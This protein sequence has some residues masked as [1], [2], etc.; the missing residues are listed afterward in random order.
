MALAPKQRFTDPEDFGAHMADASRGGRIEPL[1]RGPFQ[2]EV[3]LALLPRTALFMVDSSNVLALRPARGDLWSATVPM[4]GGFSA[5][6][7]GAGSQRDFAAGEIHL[8]HPDRDFE[9]RSRETNRALAVN[10]LSDDLQQKAAALVAARPGQPTEV[11]TG[12]SPAGAALTRFVHHFW[13]ELQRPG[14]LWDSTMA[15]AEM[16]DCLVSLLALAAHPSAAAS[17]AR[18]STVRKA[19]DFLIRHL[20]QPLTRSDLAEAVGASIRTI[21]RGFREHHGVSP[22]AW[23]KARRLEA[24]Q[25]ELRDAVPGEVTVTEVALRCGFESLG[26]FAAEYR[27]RFGETPSQTLRR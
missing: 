17:T 27:A 10:I 13:A 5:T 12:A 15:L 21:S 3:S 18:L 25:S 7:G 4:Q 2:V 6:V 11:V 8:L 23:L 9:Y 22:M 26:R 1:K 16:E 14:G 20:T 24:A 19:E